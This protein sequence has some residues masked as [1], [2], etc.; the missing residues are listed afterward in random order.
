MYRKKNLHI[1]LAKTCR[2]SN[3]L[4]KNGV[5]SLIRIRPKVATKNSQFAEFSQSAKRN[6]LRVKFYLEKWC[7]KLHSNDPIKSSHKNRHNRQ[8][9]EFSIPKCINKTCRGSNFVRKN[10]RIFT[11]DFWVIN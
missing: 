5:T 8:L 4:W 10:S 1:L 9:P 6:L 3:N 11:V 7:Y 2:G